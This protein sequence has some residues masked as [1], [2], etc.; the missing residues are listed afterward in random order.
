MG[1][2]M[3]KGG[4][5]MYAPYLFG[6]THDGLSHREPISPNCWAGERSCLIGPFSSR[7]VARTFV[8]LK[9]DVAALGEVVGR[10]FAK[11]DA[12]Y[13]ELRPWSLTT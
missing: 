9:V 4:V 7:E 2:S 6:G 3:W 10:I 1:V 5:G 13:V 8:S 12:W 11:G